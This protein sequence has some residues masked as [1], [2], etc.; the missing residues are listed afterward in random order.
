MISTIVY[1]EPFFSEYIYTWIMM[2]PT[3]HPDNRIIIFSI[4]QFYYNLTA[5]QKSFCYQFIKRL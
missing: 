3:D 5:M 4:E 1:E 2:L